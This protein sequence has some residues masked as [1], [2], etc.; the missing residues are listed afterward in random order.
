MT[1]RLYAHP[2]VSGED[3]LRLYR[4]HRLVAVSL[5]ARTRRRPIVELR[6]LPRPAWLD[7]SRQVAR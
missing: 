4:E 1:A 5:P 6:P 7:L 3:V 2:T